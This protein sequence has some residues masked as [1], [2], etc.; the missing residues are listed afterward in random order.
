MS[1]TRASREITSSEKARAGSA[2]SLPT[3]KNHWISGLQLPGEAVTLVLKP[4]K[5]LL[6]SALLLVV[7][8][9]LLTSCCCP[10]TTAPQPNTSVPRD[11]K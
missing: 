7:A 2:A 3:R 6:F 8:S 5:K 4:M 1:R 11:N 10:T 9:C